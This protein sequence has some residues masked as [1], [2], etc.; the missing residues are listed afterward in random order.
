ML[1]LTFV[2]VYFNI[3]I[4]LIKKFKFLNKIFRHSH[5]TSQNL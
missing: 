5:S 3:I 2:I 1:N 4:N